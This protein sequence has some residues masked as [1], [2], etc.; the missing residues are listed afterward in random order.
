MPVEV[1]WQFMNKDLMTRYWRHRGPSDHPDKASMADRI[2]VFH[3]GV[4]SV[5]P[6]SPC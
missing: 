2:L 5:R 3:R 6:G 1:N 4:T